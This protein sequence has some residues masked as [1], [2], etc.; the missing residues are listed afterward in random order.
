MGIAYC[1]ISTGEFY[2]TEKTGGDN[3]YEDVINELV[4]I[5]AREVLINEKFALSHDIKEIENLT[6]SFV[7]EISPA[8]Y[9]GETAKTAIQT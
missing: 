1:D 8:Y 6:D 2:V 9:S 4:K 5:N 3:L 7:H